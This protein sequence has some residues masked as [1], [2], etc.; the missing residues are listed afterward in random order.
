MK[1]QEHGPVEALLQTVDRLTKATSWTIKQETDQG[2]VT[3]KVEQGPLI[4]ALKAA[5]TSTQ[6]AH[7]GSSLPN[8]RSVIDGDALTKYGQLCTAILTRYKAST[9][10]LPFADPKQN[11]R[12]WFIAFT[13]DFRLGKVHEDTVWEEV[14]KLDNWV[15]VINEKLNPATTLDVTAPCPACEKTWAT[16]TEGESVQAV[17]ISYRPAPNWSRDALSNSS[18]TCRACHA[19]WKGGNAL[20]SLRFLIDEAAE[21]HAA[22]ISEP[23]C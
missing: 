22:G 10:A 7:L 9:S 8:Q 16:N 15:A 21:R 1:N 14:S 11:L 12:Q 17:Q 23:T 2:S 13:N 6:G 19:V 3:T 18:A 4:D 5:I 20:R